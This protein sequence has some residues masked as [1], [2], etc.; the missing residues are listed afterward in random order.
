VKIN[1]HRA[2]SR[3]HSVPIMAPASRLGSGGVRARV[4]AQRGPGNPAQDACI[5]PKSVALRQPSFIGWESLVLDD[6]S[7]DATRGIIVHALADSGFNPA[8]SP[9]TAAR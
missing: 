2:L 8:Q 6:E 7:P 9:S 1:R 5:R 4:H 3:P